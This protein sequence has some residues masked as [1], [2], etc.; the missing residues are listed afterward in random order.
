MLER[1][2][3]R[4]PNVRNYLIQSKTA[5]SL[6]IRS[7]EQASNHVVACIAGVTLAVTN[8]FVA[9]GEIETK[10]YVSGRAKQPQGK[11]TDI[12]KALL[13]PNEPLPLGDED[14]DQQL[15]ESDGKRHVERE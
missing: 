13:G 6:R 4:R 14:F 8:S 7:V 15:I 1:R 3:V 9:P 2:K 10:L 11:G 5:I 12:E